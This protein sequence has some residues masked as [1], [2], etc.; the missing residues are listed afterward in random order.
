MLS[1]QIFP[2]RQTRVERQRERCEAAKSKP[3]NY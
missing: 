3:M 2:T 1:K